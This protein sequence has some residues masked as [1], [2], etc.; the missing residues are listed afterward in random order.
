MWC[1]STTSRGYFGSVCSWNE[2]RGID[3]TGGIFMVIKGKCYS[4]K[5]HDGINCRPRLIVYVCVCMVYGW[6]RLTS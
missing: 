3:F 1:A 5:L 6:T 2:G 4:Y